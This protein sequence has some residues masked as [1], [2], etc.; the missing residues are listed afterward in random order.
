MA[1]KKTNFDAIVVVDLE[2]TCWLGQPP[3][4][5]RSEVIEIGVALL[6]R[7]GIVKSESILVK[8]TMSGISDFCTELTG[9]SW[10]T[11]KAGMPFS[12]A[13]NR[14]VEKHGSRNRVWASWGNYDRRMMKD[15]C[16][17]MGVDSPF[18]WTHINVKDMFSLKYGHRKSFSVENALMEI[19]VPFAGR[20]HSGK[21]DAF[22]IAILLHQ[23]LWGGIMDNKV[24]EI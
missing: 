23:M 19:G 10:D 1:F 16:E 24:T 9:H 8:P 6:K 22:N 2:A 5:E 17:L 4:G 20:P 3:T 7:E 15:Q 11:L 18:S 21:D 12:S 13:C 14:L